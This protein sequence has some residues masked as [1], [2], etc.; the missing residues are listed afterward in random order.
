MEKSEKS[1]DS[2][3]DLL[4]TLQRLLELPSV[5]LRTAM[6][7]AAQLV[8]EAL[9]ADKVDAFLY[10]PAKQVLR[11]LGTSDS[12][13]GRLQKSYGLDVLPIANGGSTVRTYQTG[14]PVLHGDIVEQTYEV[15]GLVNV[16]GIR[17]VLN[18][19]LE[20]AG[21][22]RGVLSVHSLN[23][24]FFSAEHLHFLQAVGRWVGALVHR[25]ELV[26]ASTAV[27]HASGRRE[28]A[29]ELILVLAHDLRNY[30]GPL[31]YRIELLH[32]RAEKEA[33]SADLQ[34]AERAGQ[35]LER[36]RRL[37]EDLL[38]VHRLEHDLFTLQR[39][40]FDLVKLAH[41][42]AQSLDTE[43][44]GVE[45]RGP[46]S[47]C[48]LGDVERIRQVL[49]NLIGNATKH[50]PPGKSVLVKIRIETPHDLV[51]RYAVVEV[52]DQGPGVLPEVLPHIFERFGRAGSAQG[53]GL[54]LYL[55]H[56]IAV[57]HRGS[58]SVSSPPG[59]GASFYLHL[60]IEADEPS[61][62]D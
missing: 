38:D 39:T 54:G 48:M 4:S 3:Q 42:S 61:S 57:A 47:L 40:T 43:E 27:A 13:L 17:A 29:E 52:S 45:V 19:P 28:I 62:K 7:Q 5:D 16:L 11:A 36:L 6:N 10:D 33:R 58:L 20:V 31:K 53:L 1:D 15:P 56:R 32:R 8:L 25:T 30:L 2:K 49:E 14:Q 37:I 26:E 59:E 12:P 21:E 60:P 22:R 55:A 34:D 9:K 35:S 51:R 50:S 46:L 23:P 24:D 44:V 41:E 18:I